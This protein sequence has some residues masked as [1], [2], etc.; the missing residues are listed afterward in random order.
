MENRITKLPV[1]VLRIT[2][3][4]MFRVSTSFGLNSLEAIFN[5]SAVC[6]TV[7]NVISFKNIKINL[8]FSSIGRVYSLTHTYVWEYVY[9][10]CH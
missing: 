7:M 6:V 10:P 9:I 8:D 4:L 3:K 2:N 1:E 5:L